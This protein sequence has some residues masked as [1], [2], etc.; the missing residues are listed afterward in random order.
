MIPLRDESRQSTRFPLVTIAIIVANVLVF[1][2]ELSGGDA[3]V[4]QWSVIPADI[5][6]GRHLVTLLTAMFMHGGWLHIIGNMVFL[7]AFGP[8][9]ED[10]MG[11]P[12]YLS[13]YLLSGLAASAAQVV[14]TPGSMVPNLGASGAI[15][16]VMGAFLITY[17]RDQIRTLVL[18][19]WFT[20]ITVIPAA[21][22]IGLWFVTQLFS[23]VGAVAD[24]QA[25]GV[26]YAAHVGGFIFGAAVG[27]LFE[28]RQ[29]TPEWDAMG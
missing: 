15:A 2:L 17:P 27:R 19:G 13:F 20:R 29:R 14:M 12:R 25:G 28:R 1:F 9:I 11:G 10:A 23:E 8:E 6:A 26:A 3:F 18:F 5:S 24:V 4:N 7:W 16:G 22:L 21:L